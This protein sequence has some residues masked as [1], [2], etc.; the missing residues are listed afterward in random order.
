MSAGKRKWVRCIWFEAS[1]PPKPVSD[2]I[3]A[4]HREGKQN[5]GEGGLTGD[6]SVRAPD[7]LE[8]LML[9]LCIEISREKSEFSASFSY[10]CK[11]IPNI[12]YPSR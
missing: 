10:L 12:S 7:V 3:G 6:L 5:V 11:S 4:G 1:H 2:G 8:A 9:K